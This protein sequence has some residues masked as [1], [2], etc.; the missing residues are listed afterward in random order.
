[1]M[2]AKRAKLKLSK[3]STGSETSDTRPDNVSLGKHSRSLLDTSGSIHND[4]VFDGKP[5]NLILNLRKQ[6]Q[7]FNTNTR[8]VQFSAFPV[9]KVTECVSCPERSSSVCEPQWEPFPE[10]C[11]HCATEP[12]FGAQTLQNKDCTVSRLLSQFHGENLDTSHLER[13]GGLL[14][15]IPGTPESD[16][17]DDMEMD[18]MTSPDLFAVSH[19][20]GKDN[21][22]SHTPTAGQTQPVVVKTLFP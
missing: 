17:L 15:V 12:P 8:Q 6:L 11:L 7:E 22:T 20:P 10:M 18:C 13:F 19:S 4:S 14:S 9:F 21:L 16:S 1:V 5:S 3:R 2:A